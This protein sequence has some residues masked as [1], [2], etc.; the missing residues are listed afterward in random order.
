MKYEDIVR[1]T[2]EILSQYQIRLTVRQI[3]YRLISPPY[4]LFPN[5]QASY[6]GFDRIITRA[7][8][9]EDVDWNRLEDRARTTLGGEGMV[10]S[11]T[12]QYVD[13][14]FRW[15]NRGDFERSYWDD[16]PSYVEAWVEKDALSSLFE[17]AAEPFRVIVFPSR[18]YSSFTKVMEAVKRFPTG[19]EV[20][21]LHFAD[22]D[23]SGVDMTRDI[24]MRLRRYGARECTVKR[25][26]LTIE[27]VKELSLPPNPTKKAD[28]RSPEY[29][30]RYGD[31][32][33]ELDAV[34][35]DRLQTMVRNAVQGEIDMDAWEETSK[36]ILK[37]KQR[38]MEVMRIHWKYLSAL[39][40]QIKKELDSPLT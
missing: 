13:W 19:K 22:H 18:G 28:V 34:P 9:N 38:I 29:I 11:N 5:T 14:L 23:P 17:I 3:Y 2:N 8:E 1:I 37:E 39:R 20:V 7:R 30:H 16:Q 40:E 4:Q 27:Q 35:P 6:K 32:C 15:L 36:R 21:I 25:V 26:A 24:W 10:F 33:W 12:G 31:A